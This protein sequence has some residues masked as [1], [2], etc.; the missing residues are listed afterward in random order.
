MA[1]SI[2]KVILVGNLGRDPEIRESEW[3][4]ACNLNIA[5]SE[6]WK[7]K[8]SGERKTKTEWHKVVIYNEGLVGVAERFLQ[9][10]STVYI[11]GQLQTRSYDKDGETRYITE[12]VLQKYRGELTMLGKKDSPDG[13]YQAPI[14]PS[15][16]KI[17]TDDDFDF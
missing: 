5:T 10:G 6:S 16:K 14:A 13:E 17:E 15:I 2:N 1:G 3:G 7:D 8:Q 12:I 11:E 4:R 9:K